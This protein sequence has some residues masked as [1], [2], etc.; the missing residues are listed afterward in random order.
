MIINLFIF[1]EFKFKQRSINL[2]V[3]LL[4]LFLISLKVN[5]F[6]KKVY[7]DLNKRLNND[8]YD[9]DTLLINYFN[10]F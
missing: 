8:R 6:Q 4:N 7:F 5:N 10:E 9:F 2:I 1:N 3:L